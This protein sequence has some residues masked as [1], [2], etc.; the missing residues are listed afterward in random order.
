MVSRYRRR[1]VLNAMRI[2]AAAMLGI[3]AMYAAGALAA[4]TGAA[5]TS[6]TVSA[7]VASL[8]VY[9][10]IS[11][12]TAPT[13]PEPLAPNDHG[14]VRVTTAS[15]AIGCSITSDLVACETLSDNWPPRGDGQ[16]YHTASV[17][18]DGEFHLVDADL[19]ALEGKVALGPR[20]Y[21]AQGWTIVTDAD[22][23]T[24]TND[25]T[26]RGM[27]VSLSGVQPF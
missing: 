15:Q 20:T 11:T 26:G 23:I 19:G 21:W 24:F 4:V 6:A 22:A 3:R 12:S 2:S 25:R 17:S 8:P 1:L 7:P 13:P 18:S 27:R 5:L 10:L 9:H 16:P 14:Y